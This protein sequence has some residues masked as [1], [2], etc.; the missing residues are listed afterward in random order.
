[1]QNQASELIETLPEGSLRFGLRVSPLL[2]RALTSIAA[3]ATNVLNLAVCF[4]VY[5]FIL[6]ATS[7]SQPFSYL[8]APLAAC[9]IGI[10]STRINKSYIESSHKLI[11]RD[12]SPDHDLIQMR[13]LTVVGFFCSTMFTLSI[14]T[15]ALS[16]PFATVLLLSSWIGILGVRNCLN[17]TLSLAGNSSSALPAVPK[18][19]D[20][21]EVMLVSLCKADSSQMANALAREC[22]NSLKRKV[23]GDTPGDEVHTLVNELMKRR[24]HEDA[25]MI[26]AHY[27]KLLEAE[28][29]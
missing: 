2:I 3:I 21:L 1:M 4:Y 23:S 22:L 10:L 5:V 26:S 8:T 15:P 25:D 24:R 7:F 17:K 6:F 11:G 14:L 9:L 28:G 27:L 12:A 20:D 18:F 13:F 19:A 16:W 29:E